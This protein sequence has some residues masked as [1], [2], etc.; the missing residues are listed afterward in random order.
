M[1]RAALFVAIVVFV[2]MLAQPWRGIIDAGVVLGLAWGVVSIVYYV[3]RA[4]SRLDPVLFSD[5]LKAAM[6]DSD[7]SVRAIATKALKQ[8]A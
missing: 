3:V 5:A 4:M 1:Q 7:A 6:Y 8:R 2:R